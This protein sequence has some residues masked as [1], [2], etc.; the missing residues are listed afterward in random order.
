[1]PAEVALVDP[2]DNLWC[3]EWK[4]PPLRFSS[5]SPAE[6][7]VDGAGNRF[8]I[9]GAGVLYAATTPE[10]SF[11][12]TMAHYRPKASLIEKMAR[13]ANDGQAPPPAGVLDVSWRST[14][15]LRR[16]ETV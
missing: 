8:D 5:I 3:V 2:P 14:R 15:M 12:E 16:L 4:E 10:G 7:V 9:P 13:A 1:M 11:A 6:A